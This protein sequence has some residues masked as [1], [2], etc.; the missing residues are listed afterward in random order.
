MGYSQGKIIMRL[1]IGL[2][3]FLVVGMFVLQPMGT[4]QAEHHYAQEKLIELPEVIITDSRTA[5]AGLSH[6]AVSDQFCRE[7][8][9][10]SLSEMTAFEGHITKTMAE[11]D[12]RKLREDM[13]KWER[14]E[15]AEKERL[16]RISEALAK[17]S[18]VVVPKAP[19]GQPP[20]GEIPENLG[21]SGTNFDEA[22]ATESLRGDLEYLSDTSWGDR[23][24]GAP[25][26]Y[27]VQDDW[28]HRNW[29]HN[30]GLRDE[31]SEPPI[32]EPENEVLGGNTARVPNTDQSVD[33]GPKVSLGLGVNRIFGPD[34]TL[35]S[36]R[37]SFD[38]DNTVP[39]VSLSF[40]PGVSFNNLFPVF[41]IYGGKLS[42]LDESIGDTNRNGFITIIDGSNPGLT[43]VT[44]SRNTELELD[45]FEIGGKAGLE[46]RFNGFD[47]Y[48]G[49]IVERGNFDYRLTEEVSGNNG[50]NFF[51]HNLDLNLR[52]TFVGPEIRIGKRIP[53]KF[54]GF[55]NHPCNTLLSLDVWAAPGYNHTSLTANQSGTALGNATQDDTENKLAFR[56]GVNLGAGMPVGIGFVQ[57]NI[58]G[59]LDTGAPDVSYPTIGGTRIEADSSTAYSFGGS[60]R[61][62]IPFGG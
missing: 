27:Y 7:G 40:T 57:L 49:L 39:E 1:S 46:G 36:H 2:L 35:G 22:R 34:L 30:I 5:R 38:N 26:S 37:D 51:T 60:L 55:H 10:V 20:F 59:G 11:Q 29:S 15:K 21:G 16:K 28:R 50:V 24:A 54:D 9:S 25:P 12:L 19:P 33:G 3:T 14:V 48:T 18:I 61:L 47:V 58:F 42:G 13:C 62:K 6:F 8:S 52:S 53:L 17:I 56:S 32:L 44:N 31:D 41:D 45:Y 4:A 43:P 23:T